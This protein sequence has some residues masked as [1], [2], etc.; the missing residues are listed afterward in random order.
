MYEPQQNVGM[1]TSQ[2]VNLAKPAKKKIS[3]ID[4]TGYRTGSFGASRQDN[5]L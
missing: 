1:S 5:H 2:L 3:T 4:T